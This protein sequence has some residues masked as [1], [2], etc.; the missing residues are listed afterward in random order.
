M[1]TKKIRLS[2]RSIRMNKLILCLFFMVVLF[3]A[4]APEETEGSAKQS[5]SVNFSNDYF[6]EESLF[7]F[8]SQ[9]NY[10]E[11]SGNSMII[12]PPGTLTEVEYI[13]QPSQ[14]EVD[15]TVAVAFDR[16]MLESGCQIG[17]HYLRSVQTG[18]E[19]LVVI[20]AT[21]GVKFPLLMVFDTSFGSA[22]VMLETIS[23]GRTFQ[24]EILAMVNVDFQEGGIY[25]RNAVIS[26]NQLAQGEV[27]DL[28]Q[29]Q[30][31][32]GTQYIGFY[33]SNQELRV[34]GICGST[35]SEGLREDL[36]VFWSIYERFDLKELL[37]TTNS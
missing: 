24:A 20:L 32:N 11:A 23:N 28:Q 21:D 3:S 22:D 31:L 9:S 1:K 8:L 25:I 26:D 5:E 37:A 30:K 12:Q 17:F 27:V 2:L 19:N 6:G 14:T 15:T 33:S 16:Q 29:E 10:E 4:C 7:R 13:P 34:K 18:Q 36:A 35:P